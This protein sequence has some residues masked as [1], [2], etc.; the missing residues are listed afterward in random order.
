MNKDVIYSFSPFL[1]SQTKD[2]ASLPQF[3]ALS[4]GFGALLSHTWD[5]CNVSY[6][7]PGLWSPPALVPPAHHLLILPKHLCDHVLHLLKNEP[8]HPYK[9]WCLHSFPRPARSSSNPGEAAR[10]L[11]LTTVSLVNRVTGL[12]TTVSKPPS[13]SLL[14][15]LS[16]DLASTTVPKWLWSG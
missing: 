3:L 7:C 11:P 4:P 6:G 5:L 12:I 8:P 15:P 1:N 16:L 10:P 2:S 14:K 13:P 9:G